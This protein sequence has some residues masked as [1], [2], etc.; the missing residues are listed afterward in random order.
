MNQKTSEISGQSLN[1]L[2]YKNPAEHFMEALPVGNGRLGVM[3][4]GGVDQERLG[5]NESTFWSG[6]ASDGHEDPNGGKELDEIRKLLFNDKYSEAVALIGK[7]MLGRKLNFGTHLP[8]G[9]L[10]LK[11]DRQSNEVKDYRRELDMDN[12]LAVVQYRIDGVQFRREV[13]VSHA[14]DLAIVLLTADKP[15]QISFRM[16]FRDRDPDNK[17]IYTIQT[18]N[19]DSLFIKGKALETIHSDGTCGVSFCG[20]IQTLA[21]GGKVLSNDNVIEVDNADTVTLLIAIQTDY[22]DSD[23]EKLC[24]EKISACK[25]KKYEEVRKSHIVDYQSLFNRVTIDLGIME[26]VNL[27][28]DERLKRQAE[29][30]HDPQLTALFFQYGRYLM[31]SGSRDNS[32]L[33]MNLQGIW[34]DNRACKMEWTCDYHLDINIQQNYWPAEVCNLSECHQPLFKLIESLRHPGQRTARV[35]YNCDGWVCHVVTNAWGYTAPG[36]GLVWGVNPTGGIWIASHLWEHYAFTCDKEFLAK[37]AYPTL[38]EA[39]QFFLE[40]MVEHPKYGYLVTGPATSPE[41]T[42]VAPDGSTAS[43][44]MGPTCDRVLVYDLFTD[45]IK[46]SEILGVD[47]DFSMELE[48]A[49]AKLPPLQIGKHGQLQ[50]WIEDFDEA[51]PNHRH[52]CHLI[53]LY[54][55]SQITVEETPKLAKAAEV[56]I[57]RRL[58]QPDWEDTEWGRAN[59]LNFYARLENGE[60]ANESILSLLKK[61]TWANLLTFSPSGI[62]GAQN[63]IFSIDGNLAATAGVAEMLLQSHGGVIRLLPALPKAWPNGSVTGLRA[64]GGFEVDINWK[65][66]KIESAV[67]RSFSGNACVIHISHEISIEKDGK[68]VPVKLAKPGIIKFGTNIGDNYQIKIK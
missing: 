37:R 49:R 5:L 53:A 38:K 34:N 31:I 52:T 40:Y 17:D 2:W 30:K 27:P 63:Q 45:C 10:W 18:E 56:T 8:V 61:F 13:L 48:K 3:V 19:Q 44:S 42:F 12:A 4:S 46:A 1:K 43:E 26:A 15:G 9:E 41:N 55:S 24:R 28:T 16:G 51:V 65:D 66:S 57:E 14:D 54:P 21:D 22:R 35:L 25:G 59:M 32:P 67:I 58:S 47:S 11:I 62:A 39:S 33:P 60:A 68:P 23:P 50:E 20:M 36:W 7:N 64:R 6:Q 29:G